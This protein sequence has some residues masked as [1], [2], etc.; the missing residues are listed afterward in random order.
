MYLKTSPTPTAQ[1]VRTQG[2]QEPRKLIC[3][4]LY[5]TTAE[6]IMPVSTS[7][8]AVCRSELVIPALISGHL[9]L[10]AAALE[11]K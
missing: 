6:E 10:V 7:G 5:D 11:A 9:L 2:G 3:S 4:T 1:E 8:V